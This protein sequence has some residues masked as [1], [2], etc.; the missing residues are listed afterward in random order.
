MAIVGNV[1]RVDLNPLERSL[2]YKRLLEEFR[3]SAIEIAQRVGKSGPYVTN[4]LRLLELPDALKDGLLSG[5]TTEGH[6]RALQ[7]LDEPKL[8][9]QAYKIVLE[10]NLSVRGAEE[11]SRRMKAQEGIKPRKSIDFVHSPEIEQ[12]ETAIRNSL[13]TIKAELRK[14]ARGGRLILIFK[15]DDELNNLYDKLTK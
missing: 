15:T 7:A 13:G 10:Q 1:Q 12:M 11:L 5:I 9:V 8:I 3:M 14:S 2:A 6:V 4:T